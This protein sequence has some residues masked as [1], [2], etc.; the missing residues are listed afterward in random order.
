MAWREVA[1]RIAHE[2]KNPLTPIKLSAQRMQRRLIQQGGQDSDFIR[3]CT[4]TIITHT[5]E[6]RDLVNEFSEF[7]RLPEVSPIP[8]DLNSMVREV[9]A[10]YMPAHPGIRFDFEAAP[11]LP[12]FEF[13]R[14][15]LKRVL[16]NLLEN[17]VAAFAGIDAATRVL[18]VRLNTQYEESLGLATLAVR[19]N[20][21]GMPEDVLSRIFEPY[22]STKSEGTGLGLAIAKRIVNDHNGF[23]R[24]NAEMGGGTEFLIELPTVQ[25]QN[26]T[27]LSGE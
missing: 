12:V 6:L 14:E 19:D 21:P 23:I 10:L 20:G 8:N 5:D 22:F 15:Q 16:I 26:S 13:D 17:S 7:A 27:G 2:I 3:E 25:R 4:D 1:R 9:L 11:N 18:C 24:V